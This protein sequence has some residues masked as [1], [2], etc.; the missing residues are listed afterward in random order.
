MVVVVVVVRGAAGSYKGTYAPWSLREEVAPD[1]HGVRAQTTNRDDGY[2]GPKHPGD[3]KSQSAP[4]PLHW[5][6][7]VTMTARSPTT[8]TGSTGDG[9]AVMGSTGASVQLRSGPLTSSPPFQRTRAQSRVRPSMNARSA[10]PHRRNCAG[11]GGSG[12]YALEIT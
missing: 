1:A 5:K 7:L 4:P 2:Y 11:D 3:P 6:D 8:R 10:R 12:K 9:A